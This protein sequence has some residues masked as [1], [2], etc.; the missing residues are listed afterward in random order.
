MK[1]WVH[2]IKAL[3]TLIRLSF[4]STNKYFF[5][6]HWLHFCTPY[7]FF[8]HTPYIIHFSPS[9][10][11]HRNDLFFF[12]NTECPWKLDCSLECGGRTLEHLGHITFKVTQAISVSFFLN[13][14]QLAV[15]T[16]EATLTEVNV[17]KVDSTRWP[18]CALKAGTILGLWDARIPRCFKS[19]K[20]FVHFLFIFFLTEMRLSINDC[21]FLTEKMFS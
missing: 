8:G 9:N 18:Q 21:S 19:L 2:F 6:F 17:C 7:N 11:T 15:K 3:K 4:S 5:D 12:H 1:V 20:G 10:P 16:L 14:V 13:K